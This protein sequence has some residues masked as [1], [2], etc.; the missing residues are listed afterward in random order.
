M[1]YI[2]K[3]IIQQEDGILEL[4]NA[5]KNIDSQI[6]LHSRNIDNQLIIAIDKIFKRNT[7][8]LM[9]LTSCLVYSSGLNKDKTSNKMVHAFSKGLMS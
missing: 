1:S 6:F 9:S 5:K 7:I 3:I 2:L 4:K 8:D